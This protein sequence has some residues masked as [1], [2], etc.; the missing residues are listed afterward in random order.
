[1][2][3]NVTDLRRA[4]EEI[5]ENYRQLR[6]AEAETR[7]ERDRL[8]L[9]L[10]SVLDPILVT[11][12][13]G[14]IVLMNP[15]AERMFTV[16]GAGKRS[17]EVG[18]PGAGQRRGVHLV[19]VRA[20]TRASRGAGGGELTPARSRERGHDAGRGDLGQGGLEAAA[21]R[22]RWSPSSTT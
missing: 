9:I 4:T 18:A 11:D 21:R 5:E 1:M 2:L 14:N 12:P 19:R 6:V 10:N 3:R 13:A 22:R 20:S 8:D 16:S 7:A 15:P 17:A